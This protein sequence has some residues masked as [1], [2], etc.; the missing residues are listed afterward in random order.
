MPDYFDGNSVYRKTS[1][2][3]ALL[4]SSILVCVFVMS[5]A[6]AQVFRYKQDGSVTYGDYVPTSGLDAGHS[7]L[8]NQGVVLKQVKSR[9]ERREARRKEQEAKVLRLRDKTLLRTFTEEED[10]TRTRD[11]RL[12]LVDGH[13]ARLGDRVRIA[14]ENLVSMD[15][16]I[17]E[18]ESSKG[19]GKAPSD[20]Y[21]EKTRLKN[22]IAN[23]WVL[24]DSKAAERKKIATKFE[25]D[26]VRY[27][28]LK[29]G[30]GSNF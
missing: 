2:R 1:I 21:A 7:V 30:G 24:I 17:R 26:L 11:D 6:N 10:L 18:A 27:R 15:Q 13:I 25:A 19:I 8:N 14:K 22:K 16:R 3:R 12:G 29:N 5:T 20:F 28:R 23:T 9:E 4:V